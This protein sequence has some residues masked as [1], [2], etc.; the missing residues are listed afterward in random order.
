MYKPYY[1]K[2]AKLAIHSETVRDEDQMIDKIALGK[3]H[4]I[5][6]YE[7][8]RLPKKCPAIESAP[9]RQATADNIFSF[10]NNL[11]VYLLGGIALALP[12]IFITSSSSFPIA[13]NQRARYACC[14]TQVKNSHMSTTFPLV[15]TV[16]GLIF[17]RYVRTILSAF[18]GGGGFLPKIT[19]G[20]GMR[21]SGI[22]VC[23]E[24]PIEAR[25][26]ICESSGKRRADC[27][28][29]YPPA[30]CPVQARRVR[31]GEA[32]Q[33]VVSVGSVS[34]SHRQ[35]SSMSSRTSAPLASGR[36]R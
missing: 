5:L 20:P 36:R 18:P 12:S 1:T 32:F 17:L 26:L 23:K 34:C 8:L 33:V 25:T 30:D 2:R 24:P 21:Q 11:H 6:G 3:K 22:S 19:L 15:R 35:K 7:F 28:A 16:C 9:D 10:R 4:K 13:P 14:N 27:T 31:S 29:K